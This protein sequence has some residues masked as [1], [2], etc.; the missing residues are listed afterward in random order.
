MTLLSD[1]WK[2]T[3]GA[4]FQGVLECMCLSSSVSV[5]LWLR[6]RSGFD[7]NPRGLISSELSGTLSTQTT[8]LK[9]VGAPD[10]TASRSLAPARLLSKL[11]RLESRHKM[12][13]TCTPAQ[14][15]IYELY[16]TVGRHRT[17]LPSSWPVWATLEGLKPPSAATCHKISCP[18][19]A[20]I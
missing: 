12:T 14:F 8:V 9:V 11:P 6:G 17:I 2:I 15:E 18:A 3:K 7:L 13:N 16:G 10:G 20:F 4:L 5:C 19:W 1:D